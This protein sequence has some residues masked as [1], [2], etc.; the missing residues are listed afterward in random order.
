MYIYIC[1]FRYKICTLEA[2]RTKSGSKCG[3]LGGICGDAMRLGSI[4]RTDDR[5]KGIFLSIYRGKG[6]ISIE[7]VHLSMS[8]I[9]RF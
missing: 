5:K 1:I 6:A 7:M 2:I 4:C 8:T 9:P 3:G